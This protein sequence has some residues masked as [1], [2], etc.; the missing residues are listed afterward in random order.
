LATLKINKNHNNINKIGLFSYEQSNIINK[1]EILTALCPK[2]DEFEM[3]IYD[4]AKANMWLSSI[5][6]FLDNVLILQY[7]Y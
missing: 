4:P 1:T 7:F 5:E 3:R 2:Y 6:I